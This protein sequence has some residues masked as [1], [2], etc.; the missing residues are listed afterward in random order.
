[1]QPWKLSSEF[2]S[3]TLL[4]N[5]NLTAVRL[6]HIFVQTST[7]LHQRICSDVSRCKQDATR[8]SFG[9]DWNSAEHWLL[10]QLNI[11]EPKID[12]GHHN[13]TA[14]DGRHVAYSLEVDKPW[15]D[16]KWNRQVYWSAACKQAERVP[17][18]LRAFH[19]RHLN[20]PAC[21]HAGFCQGLRLLAHQLYAFDR[22]L[23]EKQR[24]SSGYFKGQ[25]WKIN[26]GYWFPIVKLTT[27]L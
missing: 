16:T 13:K 2:K 21:V 23:L 9:A 10:I 8:E 22:R 20:V 4:Q 12:V 15:S 7:M 24:G 5:V 14:Q 26:P 19:A 1:M 25:P 18:R 27:R 17:Q 3:N 11:C 6:K